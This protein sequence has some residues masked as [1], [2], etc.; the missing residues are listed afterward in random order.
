M[1]IKKFVAKSMREALM[2][3]KSELGENAVILKTRKLPGK[4]FPFGGPDIE[5]TAAVDEEALSR[6]RP[7][8][9]EIKVQE[10]AAAA[11]GT[12]G[13]P[14]PSC[15]VDTAQP[16]AIK[17]WR[18]PVM[19]SGSRQGP[20]GAGIVENEAG[21]YT[22]I[23]ED[24]KQLAD[25]VKAVLKKG[26][27]ATEAGFSEGWA[28]LYKRLVD[29]EVKPDIAS[30]LVN[31]MKGEVTALSNGQAETKL[32]ELLRS[33]FP[34]SGPI[35]CKKRGPMVVAF[36]GPTGT[37]KTTTLAK[38]A[39]HCRL[40]KSKRVS[41]ITA[42]TY[43]IAAIDQIRTFADIIKAELQV[44]FSPDEVPAALAACVN[45]DLVFV[46]TAGRSQRNAPH[47][48]ELK[49]MLGRI[50]PDQTHL[51]VSATTKDS[52]LL[53]TIRRYRDVGTDRLVFTKLDET[54]SVG[55]VFNAVAVSGLPVSFF[56]FGQSVPD[57]IELAQPARFVQRLWEG[58][59]P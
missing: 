7:V 47:M 22:E 41:I 1:R 18:P 25:M 33:R 35:Q 17:P 36:V 9:P 34:A 42:D 11:A 44:V 27:A 57:D 58:S 19:H 46:D 28:V 38:L 10:G 12:Y 4:I 32:R 54:V 43:R 16:V 21:R 39:A 29:S 6:P 15:I 37:G 24:I 50:R 53:D 31:D 5:V 48:E 45:D 3:I 23:K 59:A 56:G 30:S 51:V 55:N 13:R 26:S 40:N 14:R 8:F 49:Q 2:S 20:T 52:D